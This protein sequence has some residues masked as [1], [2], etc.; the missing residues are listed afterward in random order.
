MKKLEIISLF[1]AVLLMLSACSSYKTGDKFK[2]AKTIYGA[3]T[4]N[5][6][7]IAENDGAFN[8]DGVTF[9]KLNKKQEIK[10][11]KTDDKKEMIRVQL[12]DGSDKGTKW[13]VKE[14]ELKKLK[15]KNNGRSSHSYKK[16]YKHGTHHSHSH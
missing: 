13:W 3:D 5:H 16:H 4:I 12:S 8:A 6:W 10:V 14:S 15:K 2:I 7:K 1:I 11:I 9:Y